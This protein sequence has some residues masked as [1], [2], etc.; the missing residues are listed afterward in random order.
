V[1]TIGAEGKLIVN[2]SVKTGKGTF[3]SVGK[4]ATIE[5]GK[6][7]FVNSN[8]TIISTT[9]VK[10]GDDT[11]IG[12]DSEIIDTDFHSVGENPS[13]AAPIEIGS[14][15]LICHRVLIMKGITIGDGAVIA[16]GSVVTHD[17][18]PNCLVAGVPAKVVRQGVAWKY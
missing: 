8:A 7:I 5:L 18:P 14:R 13:V 9:S 10:I 4:R 3:I 16:S 2:G 12:W 11:A 15:V 6:N 1:L 17:V